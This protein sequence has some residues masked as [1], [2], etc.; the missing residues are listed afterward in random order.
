MI[1]AILKGEVDRLNCRHD[2]I[3]NLF[4]PLSIAGVNP[5]IMDPESL[6]EDKNHYLNRAKKLA[7][8][9]V[10]NFQKFKEIPVRIKKAG[11]NI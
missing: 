9:F 7:K 6:W 11:P 8:L 5:K 2:K 1:T 3:F 10:K 4:I